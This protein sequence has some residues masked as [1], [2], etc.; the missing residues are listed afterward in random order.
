MEI[1][2]TYTLQALPTE[3]WD[4]L[5]DQQT[6]QRAVTGLERL[7]REDMHSYTFVI[8]LRHAPLR[9]TYA[10][11]ASV[12]EQHYPTSSILKIEGEGQPS[13]F[14]GEWHVQ[15]SPR[16]ENTVVTY[17]GTI[18]LG[19]SGALIPAPLVKGTVRVLIGHF[20][21]TLADQLRTTSHELPVIHEDMYEA[22]SN[23]S[24]RHEA[25][26]EANSGF[27]YRFVHLAKLGHDDPVSEERWVRRLRRVGIASVLLLLVWIGTRLPRRFVSHS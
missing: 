3:V 4:S 1:E 14:Y 19:K 15:L 7:T 26:I 9:G 24:E 25:A 8:H 22:S 11:R 27:L 17:K 5:M 23:M 16:N 18:H 20:F 21:T 10:G 2:G 12:L 6:V 13:R